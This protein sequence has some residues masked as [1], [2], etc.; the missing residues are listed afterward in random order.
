ML[1]FKH[2]LKK[3]YNDIKIR[4]KKIPFIILISFLMSFVIARLIVFIFPSLGIII[5]QYHIHHF[6]YGILLMII[7]NWIALTYNKISFLE[8]SAGIFGVGLGLVADEFGLLL[9]CT[10]ETLECNYLARNSYDLLVFI[11]LLLLLV[12]YY[13]YLFHPLKK[14]ANKFKKH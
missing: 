14:L 7:S 8:V 10:T 11:L 13:E 4:N 12:I 2:I 5:K 3:V 9:T 1:N 6:Y